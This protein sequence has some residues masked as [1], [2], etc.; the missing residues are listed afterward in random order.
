MFPGIRMKHLLPRLTDALRKLD[1]SANAV[2]VPPFKAIIPENDP[3]GDIISHEHF[4]PRMSK[5]FRQKDVIVA[6]TGTSAFGV[7]NVPFPRDSIFLAQILWGSIGWTT[8][9]TLGAAL[10]A[11][12]RGLGRTI[13]FIGD[14]SL[15]LTVQE[16]ST[17]MRWG[18]KPIVFVLNNKGYTIERYLHGKDR[19]YND[20][21]NWWVLCL[22]A[23]I[24][25]KAD[26][27]G[28]DYTKL[29]EVLGPD[30]K[31][32]PKSYTVNNKQELEELLET[33]SFA[34]TD[35]MQ[36]VEVMMDPLDAPIGLKRQAEL[37]TKTN[38]YVL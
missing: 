4:W 3:L 15:Q 38:Q 1:A 34:N 28:R 11:R 8:G 33:P 6:E 27:V 18:L 22:L 21:V 19:K 36:L 32:T 30:T 12:E 14:G 26:G 16:L 5:F 13:L 9:S 29:L 20:V 7:L 2:P 10:A 37:S 23:R 31:P 35:V 25:S 17:M 24:I